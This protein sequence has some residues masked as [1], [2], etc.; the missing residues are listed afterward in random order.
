MSSGLD[1]LEGAQEVELTVER[2][3]ENRNERQTYRLV[4]SDDGWRIAEVQAAEAFQPP[5]PYGAPVYQPS[6]SDNERD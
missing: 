2:V 5:I 4:R 3:Y 1:E 6:P